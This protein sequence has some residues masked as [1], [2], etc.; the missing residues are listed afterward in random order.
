MRRFGLVGGLFFAGALAATAV[1]YPAQSPK[2][3]RAAILGAANAQKSVHWIM[4]WNDGYSRQRFVGVAGVRSGWQR[5][6]YRDN[7]PT[8]GH[9]YIEVLNQTV[10]VRGDA[11]GLSNLL[12]R[13]HLSRTRAQAYAGRWIS[14]PKGDQAYRPNRNG[15]LLHS[16]VGGLAPHGTLSTVTTK[17]EGK[18]VVDL[19]GVSGPRKDRWIFDLYVP[20][21]G[22]K[23][24]VGAK[25]RIP[26]A[27]TVTHTALSKW[28]ER[29]NLTPPASST[30]I[31]TVRG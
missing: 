10:Y 5:V 28:N 26:G 1:A 22:D 17:F 30:P 29:L 14:I 6:T 4:T 15:I 27:G 25:A 31:S 16:F 2:A 13:G 19:R 23:L 3:M 9:L 24:P 11:N 18:R 8:V 12:E 21:N 7:F 20:A